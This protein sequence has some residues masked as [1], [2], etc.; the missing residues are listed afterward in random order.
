MVRPL[1]TLQGDRSLI[2]KDG[3]GSDQSLQHEGRRADARKAGNMSLSREDKYVRVPCDCGCA[4]LE[5]A[6]FD[7]D[8]EIQFEANVLDSRYDHNINGL[9]GRLRRAFGVLVSKPVYF[10]GVSL[11]EKEFGELL[12]RLVELKEG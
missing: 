5:F 11:T 2:G 12:D 10:N 4:T 8:G 3:R 6:R 1:Q 9:F 7:W